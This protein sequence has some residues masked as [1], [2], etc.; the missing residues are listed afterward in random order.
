MLTTLPPSCADCHEIWES[1]ISGTFRACPEITVFFN[2]RERPRVR[3]KD[4]VM[5]IM[6]CTEKGTLMGT[7]EKLFIHKEAN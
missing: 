6:Y 3:H 2:S 7:I 1:Q 4:D 5:D